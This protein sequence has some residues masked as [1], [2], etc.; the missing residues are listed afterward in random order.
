MISQP[1][2]FFFSWVGVWDNPKH[3]SLGSPSLELDH[4][5]SRGPIRMQDFGVTASGVHPQPSC[6]SAEMRENSLPLN[7][8]PKG[9]FKVLSLFNIFG[10]RLIGVAEL[11]HLAW[12][13]IP[14]NTCLQPSFKSNRSPRC[15]D[16]DPLAKTLQYYAYF[17]RFLHCSSL[18]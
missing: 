1:L 18:K 11:P 8:P 3:R 17:C 13:R 5:W 7:R 6:A 2:F 9:K 12:E 16:F 14:W 4:F 10:H 15:L